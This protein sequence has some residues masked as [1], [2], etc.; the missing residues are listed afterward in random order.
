MLLKILAR[1]VLVFFAILVRIPKSIGPNFEAGE[2]EDGK[3]FDFFEE[4]FFVDFPF[5][6]EAV[7]IA[8]VRDLDIEMLPGQLGGEGGGIEHVDYEHEF[9]LAKNTF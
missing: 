4:C 2:G 5:F 6:V 8:T 1:E 3:R 9:I 7:E